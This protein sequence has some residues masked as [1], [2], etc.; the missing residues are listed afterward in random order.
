MGKSPRAALE[1]AIH[2]MRDDQDCHRVKND[3]TVAYAASPRMTLAAQRSL[4]VN[5]CCLDQFQLLGLE[6]V[7]NLVISL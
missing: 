6:S 4:S 2:R 5:R 3:A 7:D 1:V